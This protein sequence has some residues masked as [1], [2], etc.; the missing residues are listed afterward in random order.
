MSSWRS[1]W[2]VVPVRWG[3]YW[4]WDRRPLAE[5]C[6]V[7]RVANGNEARDTYPRGKPIDE[8]ADKI[9]VSIRCH[10]HWSKVYLS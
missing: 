8:A 4:G 1:S 2:L 7:A 5:S 6:R 3:S 10:G 9:P